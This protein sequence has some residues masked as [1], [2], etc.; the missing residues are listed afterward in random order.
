MVNSR[1][2]VDKM[3]VIFSQNIRG[4]LLTIQVVAILL[5]LGKIVLNPTQ[6]SN[7]F[8]VFMFPENV[9]LPKWKL[10]K[11][12]LIN[13]ELVKSPAYIQ[14]DYISGKKYYYL[15]KNPNLKLNRNLYLNI[16][17]RYLVNT[18]GSLKSVIKNY[19]GTLSPALY[20]EK[21]IGSYSIFLHQDTVYLT[22]CIN[23]HGGSTITVDEFY[24]NRMLYDAS[25]ERIISWLFTSRKII[26]NRCLWAHLSMPLNNI[27]EE[28]IRQ[29]LETAW[30]DWYGWWSENFPEL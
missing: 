7:N 5:V 16:E 2:R 24:K 8:Q 19:T 17:M 25:L 3:K 21:E 9:T 30:F 28:V 12:G 6:K 22:S 11:T 20:Q 26:D 18:N 29:N 15:K 10:V 23:P 27:S 1:L 14:G 13:N 4:L